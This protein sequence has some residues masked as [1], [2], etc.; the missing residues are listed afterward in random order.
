MCGHSRRIWTTGREGGDGCSVAGAMR[1]EHIVVVDVGCRVQ[2]MA[3]DVAQ[4]YEEGPSG[5]RPDQWRV[6][7]LLGAE[8]VLM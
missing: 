8:S 6:E 5:C 4:G 3:R 1:Y 2:M 7:N